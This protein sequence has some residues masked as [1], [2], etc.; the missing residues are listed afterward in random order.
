[1]NNHSRYGFL[2]LVQFVCSLLVVLIH[3][4]QITNQP[5]LHF[6]IKSILCRIAVPFFFVISSFCF[7]K[8]MIL[9]STVPQKWLLHFIKRYCLLSLLYLPFG[10]NFIQQQIAL[11]WWQIPFVLMIG[12]FYA[13]IFYHLWYFPALLLALFLANKLL[14]RFNY[15]LALI[16]ATILYL[17]GLGE[18]YYGYLQNTPIGPFYYR[19]FTLFITT[20]NGLF[21]GLIFVLLGFYLYDSLEKNSFIHRFNKQIAF[22]SFAFF[23]LEGFIIYQNPGKDKNFFLA[24]IPLAASLFSVVIN[25]NCSVKNT[26]NY[27]KLG[28]TIYFYHLIPIEM[29]NL[30]FASSITLTKSQ[31][32]FLRFS[33][34]IGVPLLLA[35]LFQR[36]IKPFFASQKFVWGKMKKLP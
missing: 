16:L 30:F 27:Q 2:D 10:I 14:Q 13:G 15:K 7:R 24:L 4:G 20:K 1:M 22:C 33:L 36:L 29:F 5:L 31:L 25:L 35:F 6:F 32:G 12:I 8:K 21:Y 11:S 3:V 9:T 28:Q 17:F 34:G 23:L 18:T 19:F 26:Q